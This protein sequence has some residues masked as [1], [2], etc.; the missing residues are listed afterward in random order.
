MQLEVKFKKVHPDAKLPTRNHGNRV[1]N[2]Y[3]MEWLKGENER[4]EQERPEHF[5]AGYRIGFPFQMDA[6]GQPT[7]LILGTGDT[8][9]DV[10]AVEDAVVPANGSVVVAT[11]I[12]LAYITSGYW[13]MICTRSGLGF[14]YSI[15]NHPGIIDNGYNGNL[16]IKMYNLS[17]IE[18]NVTKGD[19]I[20]QIVFF[21]VIEPKISWCDSDVKYET[22]RG[23]GGFGSSGK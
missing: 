10:Y 13:F 20:A 21:P 4:F 17:N 14:K 18:Y 19:R 6:Q 12:D 3:E 8:G 2:D 22:G 11:G 9:Y 5:A 16:G 23:S 7:E 1:I 15:F